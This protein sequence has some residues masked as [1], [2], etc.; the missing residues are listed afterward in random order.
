MIY[1][2]H[3]TSG[4]ASLRFQLLCL[5]GT[6]LPV[7]GKKTVFQLLAKRERVKWLLGQRYFLP[8]CYFLLLALMPLEALV[9]M[10]VATGEL[11]HLHPF[12]PLCTFLCALY[13]LFTLLTLLL[14]AHDTGHVE[15]TLE[16][17][18]HGCRQE[19]TGFDHAFSGGPW[20]PVTAW[21]WAHQG[22][23]FTSQ[24]CTFTVYFCKLKH[25]GNGRETVD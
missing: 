15:V 7:G 9:V 4:S 13:M 3:L 8:Y 21:V 24:L 18:L 20:N 19:I 22:F 5:R 1:I 25:C 2:L 12:Y 17:L 23:R 16:T 6:V 14:L 10:G 11:Y